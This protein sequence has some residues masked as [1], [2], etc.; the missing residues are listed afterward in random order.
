[1]DTLLLILLAV[2]GP[3]RISQPPLTAMETDEQEAARIHSI[4]EDAIAVGG[5]AEDATLLL[6]VSFH[7]SGWA[8]DVDLGPCQRGEPGGP[9]RS[10]CDDSKAYCMMQ[11]HA[12]PEHGAELFKDR[13]MCFREGLAALHASAKACSKGPASEQ[14]GVYAAGSCS[15]LA[16]KRGSRALFGQW[17]TLLTRYRAERARR[18]EKRP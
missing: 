2:I 10:R 6:A 4:V 8:A 12:S 17:R 14:F 13:R 16:A 18:E 1:M 11:I 9:F 7:E 5:D 3:M 15:T